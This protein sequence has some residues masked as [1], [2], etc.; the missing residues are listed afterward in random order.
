MHDIKKSLI[1]CAAL[2]LGFAAAADE[3]EIKGTAPAKGHQAL[4]IEAHVGEVEIRTTAKDEISWRLRL[5][6]DHDDGWFNSR[7]DAERAVAEAEVKT[8]AAGPTFELELELPRGTDFDDVEEHWEIEVPARFAIEVEANVGRVEVTGPTGGVEAELNVGELRIDV[9][10]GKVDARANVGEV[11]VLS[12][13]K[14]PGELRLS[15]NIGDVDLRIGDKRV[16]AERS[17]ALG[18]GVSSS[19][20]GKDDISAKVNVGDVSVRID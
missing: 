16:Q 6:P 9:P 19:Q 8:T 7:K 12:S 14:S 1:V 11:K 3:R 17:F 15:A 4:R 5:E 13:T 20:G 10:S 2:A 18:G